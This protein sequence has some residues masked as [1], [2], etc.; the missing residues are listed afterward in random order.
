M[1]I[2]NA[3]EINGNILLG[4][5]DDIVISDFGFIN[6]VVDGGAGDDV[7]I[8]GAEDNILI[9]GTG[10]DTLFGGDGIDTADFSDLNGVV[11]D[12]KEGTV[13]DNV[14]FD[15][16]V[17]KQPLINPNLGITNDLAPAD[18]VSEAI[19]GNIYFNVHTTEFPSG[20]IRG[21]LEFVS[22]VKEGG[23][24]VVTLT[25]V[26]NG[27]QEVPAP[28]DSPAVGEATVTFR[29]DSRGR[30]VSYET[31]LNVSGLVGELLP[32]NIGNGTLSPIHL[33][34]APIGVNGPVVVDVATD[35][36]EGLVINADIDQ[37]DEIENVILTRGD[38]LALAAELSSI[39][40]IVD[41]SDGI[42]TVDFSGF[43]KGGVVVDLDFNAPEGPQFVNFENVIGTD[44]NDVIAGNG[45]INVLTGGE[46]DDFFVFDFGNGNDVVTDFQNG[47]DLLD[48]SGRGVG[49]D[50]SAAIGGA[51]QIE[52]DTLVNLG[53]GDSVLL[54]NFLLADLDATDFL[55]GG[56]VE[57]ILPPV[58]EEEVVFEAPVFEAPVFEEEV[59]EAP[60]FEEEVVFE[61]PAFEAPVFEAPVFEE[62]VFEAPA[63]EAPE[64]IVEND[65]EP[66]FQAPAAPDFGGDFNEEFD[67]AEID[68][69]LADFD[70]L[71]DEEFTF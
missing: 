68:A 38:D 1:N 63:F 65:F 29:L 26:L 27:A 49:F 53:E 42:D 9:G 28:T 40:G 35:A 8:T 50:L 57:P 56:G 54:Q 69:L 10:S 48:V 4:D 41:G 12:L 55:V 20:E 25:S 3:G 17:A 18:I 7:I 71:F 6:G 31:D 33:H 13:I 43:I 14:G 22:D 21:Q 30:V 52:N 64:V 59:F 2:I 11:I 51:Q 19:A 60:V 61:E 44:F 47:F 70:G 62:E 37:L 24:R 58:V 46:G 15:A 34:N 45:G 36:G 39:N 16:D 66:D 32:V 5:G 23:F 67:I